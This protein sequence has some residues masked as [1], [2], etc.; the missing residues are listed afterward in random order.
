MEKYGKV[1]A[2]L[3]NRAYDLIRTKCDNSDTFHNAN[4]LTRINSA[5]LLA[6]YHI[7]AICGFSIAWETAVQ[8]QCQLIEGPPVHR[9][10]QVAV[11]LVGH[12]A[13][14]GRSAPGI[15]REA[16]EPYGARIT[17]HGGGGGEISREEAA[18]HR[19]R[20][21]RRYCALAAS[22]PQE[23]YGVGDISQADCT[24][25]CIG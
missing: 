7:A 2:K 14:R 25:K 13:W 15:C 23:R 21:T 6:E 19:D 5:F 17:D 4:L 20:A 18:A 24:H 10:T 22:A 16:V 12:C 9:L 8:H 11:E 1:P 3:N